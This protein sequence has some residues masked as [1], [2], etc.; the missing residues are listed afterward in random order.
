MTA[1]DILAKANLAAL[2]AARAKL[3]DLYRAQVQAE[4][5][6]AAQA[7]SQEIA[8]AQPEIARLVKAAAVDLAQAGG[9]AW[10]LGVACADIAGLDLPRAVATEMMRRL[11]HL[12]GTHGS[13]Q[14]RRLVAGWEHRR[15]RWQQ[16]GQSLA[17]WS[18]PEAP[19]PF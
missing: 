16:Q 4:A 9:D 7:S 12:A 11:V 8:E 13:A 10:I 19:V 5:K 1:A 17:P 3:L 14:H 18:L 2:P 6:A 15:S